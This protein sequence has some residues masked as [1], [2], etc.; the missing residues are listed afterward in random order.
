VE[1]TT[2]FRL[3]L[4]AILVVVGILA[5]FVSRNPARDGLILFIATLGL[6][7]RT[8]RLTDALRIH[9]AEFALLVVLLASLD[10][11]QARRTSA[12]HQPLPW[13][14]WALI[15]FMILGWLPRDQNPFDW[16]FQLAECINVAL[17]VPTFLAVRAVLANRESWRM[18]VIGLYVLGTV[19]AL[20][21]GME[22]VYPNI[23]NVL[24]GFVSN[25][26]AYESAGGFLRAAYSFYGSTIAVFL[27]V[28]VLPFGLAL[29]SWYPGL[30]A[31]LA[32]ATAAIIQVGGVYISGYR[33][34]WLMVGILIFLVPLMYRRFL[35]TGVFIAAALICFQFLPEETRGRVESLEKLLEGTPDDSSGI[36]RKER[37]ETAFE[38]VADNPL[39][40]GWASAGW[41]HSDFLQVS[42]N[43][44]LL[45]GLILFF[46]YL[47]TLVPLVKRLFHPGSDAKLAPL[48]LSLF[49]SFLVVGQ[50]LLVQGVEFL[51]FTILPVWLVWALSHIWLGQTA[52]ASQPGTVPVAKAKDFVGARPT[53]RL[54]APATSHRLDHHQ[55]SENVEHTS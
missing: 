30:L 19:V 46:G 35:I 6:G 54:A 52:P 34:Q 5:F 10:V 23:R 50:M 1:D 24:P 18:V 25:P 43:L 12:S 48:G 31:R 2:S 37:I 32:T 27:C 20:L 45:A 7:F 40:G 4:I 42:A 22:Y 55:H 28:L 38:A 49:L 41:V 8:I 51:P 47:H 17:V 33:S 15:P 29:W 44:G 3:V 53:V 39:G 16:D 36:K 14:V 13:W 26:E 11:R 21:G 9:P